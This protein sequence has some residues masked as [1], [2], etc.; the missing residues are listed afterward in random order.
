MRATWTM[1][2]LLGGVVMVTGCGKTS[3]TAPT[4][5]AE[6]N[7][8][9]ALLP[10]GD[11][12]ENG[13]LGPEVDP[14]PDDSEA[15]SGISSA[16]ATR[17]VPTAA[18]TMTIKPFLLPAKGADT[19]G[20]KLAD[21]GTN[22]L[23]LIKPATGDQTF[24]LSIRFPYTSAPWTCSWRLDPGN[25]H[26]TRDANGNPGSFPYWVNGVGNNDSIEITV[27]SAPPNRST[28][29]LTRTMTVEDEGGAQTREWF[30]L[31]RRRS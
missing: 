1:A 11:E 23:R 4:A 28:D 10:A 16:S 2:G 19:N 21:F 12:F 9:T 17:A 13:L 30:F 7:T 6:S 8:A 15:V 22:A 31:Q 24:R 25:F 20:P 5:T 14:A 29:W 26:I 27:H 3:P 18:C